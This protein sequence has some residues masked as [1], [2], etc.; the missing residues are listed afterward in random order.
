[1]TVICNWQFFIKIVFVSLTVLS[2]CEYHGYSSDITRTWPING[3]FTP[4]QKALYELVLNVQKDLIKNLKHLPSLDETFRRMCILL[5]KKLQEIG[6]IPTNISEDK[7]LDAAYSYCPHHVSHYL[8]MDVH[9]TG[10]ISRSIQ[11][12]PGM[13]ITIEPGMIQSVISACAFKESFIS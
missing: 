9:D 13:I 10:K 8:G 4:E 2:G 12:Q 7:V 11:I 3:K 6:L 1:M 5:G